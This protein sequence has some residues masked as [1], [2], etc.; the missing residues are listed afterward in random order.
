MV[1]FLAQTLQ[2]SRKPT[3]V[4]E[5]RGQALSHSSSTTLDFS[6]ITVKQ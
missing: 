4:R 6:L 2:M 1:P 5:S 3:E